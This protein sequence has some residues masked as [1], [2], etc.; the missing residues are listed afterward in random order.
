MVIIIRCNTTNTIQIRCNNT[1]NV[2]INTMIGVLSVLELVTNCHKM[3]KL[4]KKLHKQKF[5]LV[6]SAN[7][8]Q[9]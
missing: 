4:A 1:T 5:E 3:V 9:R 6:L 2:T 8:K 7:N